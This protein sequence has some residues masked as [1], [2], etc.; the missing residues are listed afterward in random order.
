MSTDCS[1]QARI[2][3][4]SYWARALSAVRSRIRRGRRRARAAM[5]LEPRAGPLRALLQF[6]TQRP[7]A[8]ACVR[9]RPALDSDMCDVEAARPPVS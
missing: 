6:P 7:A 5:S 9:G 2:R 1:S 8:R 4:G 3:A